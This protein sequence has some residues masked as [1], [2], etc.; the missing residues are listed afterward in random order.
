MK[1]TIVRAVC[2]LLIALSLAG[3]NFQTI[4]EQDSK[5]NY[6]IAKPSGLIN[7]AG[8]IAISDHRI[9]LNEARVFIQELP[10]H[11]PLYP[12]YSRHAGENVIVIAY[13]DNESLYEY[14]FFRDYFWQEDYRQKY[15]RGNGI[16]GERQIERT[17]ERTIGNKDNFI[18]DEDGFYR[19]DGA[20]GGGRWE[21]RRT[22]GIMPNGYG[23]ANGYAI[24]HLGRDIVSFEVTSDTVFTFTD[25][26]LHFVDESS[27]D[28][29][30]QTTILEEFLTHRGSSNRLHCLYNI[31]HIMTPEEFLLRSTC[32]CA[33]RRY[34]IVFIQVKDGQVMSVT[35][36][37]LFTQ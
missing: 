14:G 20:F 1:K 32:E 23:R 28:R 6:G 37:F 34:P 12:F 13:G 3:C 35:E 9:Y 19:D 30:Y 7:L 27:M 25:T 31:D 17:I 11:N 21:L 2:L 33:P 8:W 10:P 26:N 22:Y 36:E 4:H 5:Q 15:Y 18:K 16:W 29:K 24:E